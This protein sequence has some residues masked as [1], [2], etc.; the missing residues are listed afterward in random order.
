MMMSRLIGRGRLV[1]KT[2]DLIER[3]VSNANP[4]TTPVSSLHR[5]VGRADEVHSP[6]STH[7]HRPPILLSKFVENCMCGQ[8]L[9]II[10]ENLVPGGPSHRWG[11]TRVVRRTLSRGTMCGDVGTNSGRDEFGTVLRDAGIAGKPA[12]I[13]ACYERRYQKVRRNFV[14][15]PV[16]TSSNPDQASSHPRRSAH[17]GCHR[18]VFHGKEP[19]GP[20]TSRDT[21]RNPQGETG[22]TASNECRC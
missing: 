7:P 14:Q 6:L 13:G 18:D 21:L 2:K 10:T 12:A 20:L 4:Q 16:P 8:D 9:R 1:L 3:G 15:G 17:P 5:T 22:E 19:A 11:T